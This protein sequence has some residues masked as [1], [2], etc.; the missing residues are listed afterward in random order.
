M[1]DQQ[2]VVDW[3]DDV[4]AWLREPLTEMPINRVLTRLGS[5]FDINHGNWSHQV[6]QVI[7]DRA[8]DGPVYAD[9]VAQHADRLAE[10]KAGEHRDCHP[11]TVWYERESSTQ[12]QSCA[13]VPSGLVP[14]SRRSILMEPLAVMGLEEQMMIYY[15]RDP[16]CAEFFVVA[17]GGLDF[18]DGDVAMA[19]YVQR[20]LVTLDRQAR[21]LAEARGRQPAD[22]H[23][24]IDLGLTGREVAVL[25]LLSDGLS[26]RQAA[27]QLVCSPRTV[28]KHLQHAYRK[29]EVGDRVNA[30]RVARLAGAVVERPL[31]GVTS[32]G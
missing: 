2:R 12:P 5:A 6:G 21:T 7:T 14:Q 20:S 3:L 13:R 32:D 11:L 8:F 4:L 1:S 15:R 18:D 31:E 26:A 23:P 16:S 22:A 30:I 24:L 29:L 28:E 9:F 10:F 25:Q 17:R 19:G 27:H